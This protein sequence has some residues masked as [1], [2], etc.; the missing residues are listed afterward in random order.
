MYGVS[1]RRHWFAVRSGR[2]CRT[3]EIYH[4]RRQNDTIGG[5]QAGWA[6][7][8]S[9]VEPITT[10]RDPQKKEK[11]KRG[12][13]EETEREVFQSL[14]GGRWGARSADTCVA[15]CS[16]CAFCC[17]TT[18]RALSLTIDVSSSTVAA[19]LYTPSAPASLRASRSSRQRRLTASR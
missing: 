4:S 18:L 3:R 1:A 2:A 14:G 11:R 6:G 10:P 15:C 7:R 12:K 9:I 13:S 5:H 8:D 17:G 16:L 19:P